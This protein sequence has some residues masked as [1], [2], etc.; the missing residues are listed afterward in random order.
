[1]Y[2]QALR[3]FPRYKTQLMWQ[4]SS[5]AQD[6]NAEE[7]HFDSIGTTWSRLGALAV[8]MNSLF[9]KREISVD[10]DKR[11]NNQPGSLNQFVVSSDDEETGRSASKQDKSK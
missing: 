3:Q 10:Q 4:F 11:L 5:W 8:Q 6:V 2:Q 1:M 7:V 9:N